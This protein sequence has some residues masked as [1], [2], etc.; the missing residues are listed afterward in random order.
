MLGTSAIMSILRQEEDAV[1]IAACIA[2]IR[3]V[4]SSAVT[5]LGAFAVAMARGKI[6]SQKLL[7]F[8]DHLSPHVTALD[9]AQSGL[10]VTAVKT[11]GKGRH[12]ARVNFGDCCAYALARSMA[13]PLLYKGNDFAQTA[14]ASALA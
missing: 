2:G 9:E 4:C 8:L 12:P 7:D 5:C 10:A 1:L 11:F 6:G 13:P 14:S 3:K